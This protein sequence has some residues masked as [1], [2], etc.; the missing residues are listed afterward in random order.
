MLE[1]MIDENWFY[2]IVEQCDDGKFIALKGNEVS[3]WIR[4]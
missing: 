3:Q 1:K 4:N 2:Y